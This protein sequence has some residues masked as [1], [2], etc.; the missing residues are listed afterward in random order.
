MEIQN[1]NYFSKTA[2]VSLATMDD[3]V[4][5]NIIIT[6]EEHKFSYNSIAV[7]RMCYILKATAYILNL[8]FGV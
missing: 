3:S 6:I 2:F 5:Y 4:L 7:S 1:K 8:C